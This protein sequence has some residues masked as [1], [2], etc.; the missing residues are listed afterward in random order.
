MIKDITYYGSAIIFYFFFKSRH[1]MELLQM[2]Q[3]G[4]I[5]YGRYYKMW[6]CYKLRRYNYPR[7]EPQI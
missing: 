4:I 7:A 3:K 5:N 2:C 6:H 1:L